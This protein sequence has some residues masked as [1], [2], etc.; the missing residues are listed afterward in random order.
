M[1]VFAGICSFTWKHIVSLRPRA[2]LFPLAFAA[3]AVGYVVLWQLN[4][5]PGSS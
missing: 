3:H 5:V 2:L 1:L 4:Q